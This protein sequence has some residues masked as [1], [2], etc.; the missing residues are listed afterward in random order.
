VRAIAGKIHY[1]S[2]VVIDFVDAVILLG[3]VQRQ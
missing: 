3:L 1:G 2:N